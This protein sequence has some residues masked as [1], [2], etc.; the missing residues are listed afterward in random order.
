MLT[1]FLAFV[2]STAFS[3]ALGG[4]NIMHLRLVAFNM[5]TIEA[6][7][8]RPIRPWP[9]DKGTKA[10]FEEVFGQTPWKWFVPILSKEEKRGLVLEYLDISVSIPLSWQADLFV[11]DGTELVVQSERLEEV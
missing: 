3:L 5:T 6:Y 4:F 2:F 9:Y 11:A 8:K 1:S 7:E 10:N